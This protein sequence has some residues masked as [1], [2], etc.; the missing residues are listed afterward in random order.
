[1]TKN[2]IITDKGDLVNLDFLSKVLWGGYFSGTAKPLNVYLYHGI[3]AGK[4]STVCYIYATEKEAYLAYQKYMALFETLGNVTDMRTGGLDA[5]TNLSQTEFV[6]GSATAISLV[7]TNLNPYCTLTTSAGTFSGV[8][9]N[10]DGT[11]S[12]T[13][14]AGMVTGLY[15]LTYESGNT[16]ITYPNYILI[17]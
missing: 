9:I 15:D 12:A 17:T 8:T 10:P 5:F 14:T 6:A 7:G 4:S 16:I 3:T 11:L 2:W 13:F 1:M